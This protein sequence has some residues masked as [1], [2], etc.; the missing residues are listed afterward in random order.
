MQI[1]ALKVYC[2]VIARRSFS[3]AAEDN[4][5]SQSTASQLVQQLEERLGVKLL[6]RSTRPFELTA[7][8]KRY[9]EGSRDVVR[10]YYDLE[11]EVRSLHDEAARKLVLASIYSVGLA[12]MTKFLERFKEEHPR[13]QVR[14]DYLHP[15]RVMEVVQAGEV[16]LGIMSYPQET[17]DLAVIDWR[18]EPLVLVCHPQHPLAG[19]DS[20]EL[21]ALA[22]TSFVAF[23]SD[24]AIRQA[25]DQALQS[26]GIEVN[27]ALEFDNT[28]TIKRA[29]EIDAGVSILPEPTLER[30]IALSSLQTVRLEGAPITRPVGLIHRRDRSLSEV[31]KEFVA[32]LIEDTQATVS[33]AGATHM[34]ESR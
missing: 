30:E 20:V 8:G 7:E 26:E 33:P 28:E 17:H 31:A 14:L 12:H 4:D 34:Q 19:C 27:V 16:D 24:L 21:H 25:V 32:L 18:S 13:A 2:D 9:Y 3:R 29:I 22:G 15:S 10:R 11:Q 23:E 5:M 1:K 6:D